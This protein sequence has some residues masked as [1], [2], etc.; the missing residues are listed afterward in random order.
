MIVYFDTSALLKRYVAEKSSPETQRLILTSEVVG[1]ALITRAELG[2]ALGTAVRTGRLDRTDAAVALGN[3]RAEWPQWVRLVIA[4]TTVARA[5]RLAWTLGVRGF[6]S[7]H[8]A[9]AHEWQAELGSSVVFA[10]YDRQ[11]WRAAAASGLT[12][13]PQGL[14]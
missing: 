3:M 13:W 1:T 2:A 8:L 10:T 9:A 12:A 5:D 11:L 7:V 14:V 6:D 4:E